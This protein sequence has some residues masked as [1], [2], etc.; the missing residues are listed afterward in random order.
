MSQ[1]YPS[2]MNKDKPSLNVIDTL[3]YSASLVERSRQVQAFEWGNPSI[4][5]HCG[6][7]SFLG[8]VLCGICA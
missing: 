5:T 8:C 6:W 2:D 1:S 7:H 4:N 3:N